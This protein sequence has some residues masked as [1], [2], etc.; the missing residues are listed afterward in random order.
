M[1]T[2]TLYTQ[3]EI[4]QKWPTK[5]V[6]IGDQKLEKAVTA[7]R[8]I[9]EYPRFQYADMGVWAIELPQQLGG[10]FAAGLIEA[11]A[12]LRAHIERHP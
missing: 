5:T 11:I 2:V 7:R 10:S 1:K 9:E 3:E 12:N 6:F 8:A 4:E